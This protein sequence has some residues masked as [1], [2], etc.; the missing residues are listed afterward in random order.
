MRPVDGLTE[1]VAGF[2]G[3]LAAVGYFCL[4]ILLVARRPRLTPALA[5]PLVVAALAGTIAGACV[6][7]FGP[8]QAQPAVFL[9]TVVWVAG[10]ASMGGVLT[11]T[12]GRLPSVSVLALCV[13]IG[14]AAP[15]EPWLMATAGAAIAGLF[16]AALIILTEPAIAGRRLLLAALA[17]GFAFDVALAGLVLAEPVPD[18]G[19][20]LLAAEA[21]RPMLRAALVP[22]VWLA[23]VAGLSMPGHFTPSA[24]A[25]RLALVV[26]TL[27]LGLLVVAAGAAWL[28]NRFGAALALAIALPAGLGIVAAL[29]GPGGGAGLDTLLQRHLRVSRHDYRKVWPAFVEQLAGDDQRPG[30]DLP[31]RVIR[32]VAGTVGAS[33]GGIWLAEPESRFRRLANLSLPL[34]LRD[35]DRAPALAAA[36]RAAEGPLLLAEPLPDG[37]PWPAFLPRPAAG[38]LVLPLLH[39]SELFGLLVLAAP[40]APRPLD[41]EDRELLRLVAREAASYLAEDEAARQLAEARQFENFTRRFAYIM[42]DLKNVTGELGLTLANARRL[43]GNPDFYDDLLESLDAAVTR[44]HRLIAQ[45]R[46]ERQPR[47][48]VQALVPLLKRVAAR[49]PDPRLSLAGSLPPLVARLEVDALEA[50]LDHLIDNALTAVGAGGRVQIGLERRDNM[51]TVWVRDDGPGMPPGLVDRA[52]RGRAFRSGKA[53]GLGLGLDQARH[54]VE[55]IGGRFEIASPRGG[56]TVVALHLPAPAELA[57]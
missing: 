2:G 26:L 27:A 32:A 39:R 54:T 4:A 15:F 6:A 25:R 35:G 47:L 16:T 37:S 17:L 21:A 24:G 1:N 34:A 43:R 29:A 46:S 45:L 57:A 38:W 56:G 22:I 28:G 20:L 18:G 8:Q 11:D 50:A 49:R 51:A 36:L 40:A 30:D 31:E 7:L 10:L 23:V 44:L 48:E 12:G 3:V 33:G 55:R 13:A 14:F 53:D 41:D 19:A 9:E 52:G 42:H 5:W